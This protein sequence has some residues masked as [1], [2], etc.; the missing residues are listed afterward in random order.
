MCNLVQQRFTGASRPHVMDEM[1][2]TLCTPTTA[3]M[4][5]SRIKTFCLSFIKTEVV[6][7]G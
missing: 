6:V 5:P 2:E 7:L 4:S 1:F 3:V